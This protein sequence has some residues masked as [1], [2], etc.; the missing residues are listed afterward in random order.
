MVSLSLALRSSLH[1]SRSPLVTTEGD[2]V[3]P[4]LINTC[5]RPVLRPAPATADLGCC[6]WCRQPDVSPMASPEDRHTTLSALRL[7]CHFGCRP[8]HSQDSC[9]SAVGVDH[10]FASHIAP[11]ISTLLCPSMLLALLSPSYTPAMIVLKKADTL[12][13]AKVINNVEGHTQVVSL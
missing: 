10:S 3:L 5:T 9:E 8:S 13:W 12:K 7:G 2:T 1:P 4:A 6:C 11:T